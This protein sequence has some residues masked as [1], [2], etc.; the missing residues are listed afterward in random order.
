M[1]ALLKP[2]EARALIPPT[3]NNENLSRREDWILDN[4][5]ALAS[6]WASCESVS[7][8]PSRPGDWDAF[9]WSQ[10]DRQTAIK[11]EGRNTLRQR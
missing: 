2:I 5:V 3:Y 10:W 9:C 4:A 6:W 7:D 1:N 11:H 8:E